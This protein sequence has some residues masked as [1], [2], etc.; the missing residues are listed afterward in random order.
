MQYLYITLINENVQVLYIFIPAC[1][2]NSIFFISFFLWP[3]KKKKIF[4]AFQIPTFQRFPTTIK[5]H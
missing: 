5:N 1:A 3:R 2:D 4:F